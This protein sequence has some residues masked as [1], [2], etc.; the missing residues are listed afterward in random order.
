[1]PGTLCRGRWLDL[2]AASP[3]R[4]LDPAAGWS[5]PSITWT[6]ASASPG[7]AMPSTLQGC[8]HRP[9]PQ[10]SAGG[11]PALSPAPSPDATAPQTRRRGAGHP[12]APQR[13]R[14]RGPRRSGPGCPGA[15]EPTDPSR[16][17]PSP[18]GEHGWTPGCC[19]I[20]AMAPFLVTLPA[21]LH[22]RRVPILGASPKTTLPQA[23][24]PPELIASSQEQT[25]GLKS[26][27]VPS[28]SRTHKG[29]TMDGYYLPFFGDPKQA[30]RALGMA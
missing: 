15:G 21:S 5:S 10:G 3:S 7:E 4:R 9:R 27:Q 8:H 26:N 11:L 24:A 22:R 29:Q 1:M 20:P 2:L 13:Y 19:S 30:V 25:Q 6:S 23:A 16:D 17:I 28:T 12:C 18:C 14:G